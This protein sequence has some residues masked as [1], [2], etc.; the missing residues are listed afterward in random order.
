MNASPCREIFYTSQDGLRLFARDYGD[1]L[2]PRTPAVCLPGLTR[3][4]KDFEALAT[5]LAATRRVLCP[6]F[7][8]RGRS[9]YC[10]TWSDYTPPN[11]MFDTF[12]LMAA[13][14]IHQAVFIGTSRGGIVTMLMAAQRPNTIRAA[15]LNDIGPELA[16]EGIARIAGYAGLMEAPP[17]WTEAAIRLR[18]MNEREFPS[19][20]NEEWYAFARRS[21]AEENGAPA[22]DYDPK[23]G[24]AMRKGL[25]AAGGQAPAMWPQFGALSHVPVLVIRGENSDLLTAET[26]A[27]M[28]ARHPDLQSVTVKDRG[29]A[30][31]LDEPEASAA[32]DAFLTAI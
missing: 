9:Q 18:M 7:R 6:D 30:P 29:H 2:S 11:E 20:T 25:Q 22:I 21:F 27:R 13:A 23:I 28:A 14:G 32:I 31:F 3:N 4:S 10:E 15:V 1:R 12:D 8:G 26:V 17:T 19:L 5:R 16:P 24:V